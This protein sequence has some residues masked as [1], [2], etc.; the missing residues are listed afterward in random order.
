MTI[1]TPLITRPRRVLL[2]ATY[3]RMEPLGILYLA[4]ALRD[5]SGVE[6]E[7]FMVKNGDFEA[8]YKMIADWKPDIVGVQIW[9]GWHL[10]SF[11][12][13]DR[14]RA[15]GVPVLIGGP[16]ATFC[17][18]ECIKHA[19]FVME[20]YGFTL[21]KNLV[22]GKLKPGIH[23]DLHGRDE[24]FPL[25]DRNLVYRAYPEYALNPMKS[26]F[27][28]VGCPFGCAYCYAPSFNEMHDGFKLIMS[29]MDRLMLEGQDILKHWPT[30]LIYFQDDIFGYKMEWVRDFAKRWKKE[31]GLPFHCQ[32]R[33][34]LTLKDGDERLDLLVGAGCTG[35]TLAIESGNEFIRDRVLFRH[36]P[37]ELILE[38]CKKIMDRGLTLRTQQILAVPFSDTITDLATLNLNGQINPTM[39]WASI[40]SPYGGTAFGTMADNL[41]FYKGNND[42]LS[43]TFLDRS[44]LRH[45]EGGIRDIEP[46]VESLKVPK[47]VPTKLIRKLQPLMNMKAEAIGERS[48]S[49]IYKEKKVGEITYLSP[50]ENERYCDDTVRLQRLFNWLPKMPSPET[51]GRKI[52]DIPKAEWSWETLGRVTEKHLRNQSCSYHMDGWKHELAMQ[53]NLPSVNDLPKPIA[54]NPWFFVFYPEGAGLAKKV[55]ERKFLE[56]PSFEK[57]LDKLE[58]TARKHLHDYGLLRF[59]KGREQI[60]H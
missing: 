51:L 55:V 59:E 52:V 10:Q 38:G 46:I 31:V 44:V 1:D 49:L 48:A 33:L 25:P 2:V 27:G 29:P 45:V 54:Q 26:S 60:A 13:C 22:G 20:A 58:P 53:M 36:M 40:L 42:D 14:I 23:F 16:H 32:L 56:N 15:M 35:I 4:G 11:A 50:E 12:A 9:T 43:E 17:A 18:S 21:F 3:F 6:A 28:S 5:M 24:P 57:G 30:K 37:H 34:E 19:D 8:L 39:A 47:K 41:G 7:V